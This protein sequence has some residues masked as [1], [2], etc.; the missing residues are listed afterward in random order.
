[1]Q[2]DPS[3]QGATALDQIYNKFKQHGYSVPKIVFWNLNAT[4]GR[5]TSP[6]ETHS[7]NTSYVSGFS[8]NILKAILSDNLE[9]FSPEN[10]MLEAVMK[11]RYKLG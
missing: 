11:E 4:Y 8:P 2:F 3:E 6:V 1:M 10:V 7:F 9:E 5:Y